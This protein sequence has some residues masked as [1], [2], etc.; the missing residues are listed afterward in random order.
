MLPYKEPHCGL[1][2]TLFL[3]VKKMVVSGAGALYV[4]VTDTHTD[5]GVAPIGD[6]ID[7]IIVILYKM[8]GIVVFINILEDHDCGLIT[9]TW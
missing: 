4:H 2:N 1:R 3:V 6:L 8:C 5:V 7:L 9:I